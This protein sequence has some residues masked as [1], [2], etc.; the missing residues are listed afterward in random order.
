MRERNYYE[1]CFK[2]FGLSFFLMFFVLFCSNNSIVLAQKSEMY[3]HKVGM[4]GHFGTILPHYEII[5]QNVNEPIRSLD[6]SYSYKRT[7]DSIWDNIYKY[8]ELE[9]VFLWTSL[10]NKE[11]FGNEFSIVPHLRISLYQKNKFELFSKIGMGLS[12]VTKK[13]DPY[14]NV[15][16]LAIGSRVNAHF[17]F[18]LGLG[19]SLTDKILLNCGLQFG[20]FSNGNTFNP[21]FGINYLT[22]N[23]GLAYSF[24]TMQSIG[25]KT[26]RIKI[27][28]NSSIAAYFNIGLRNKPK[29]QRDVFPTNLSFQFT[30]VVSNKYQLGAGIDVFYDKSI[31]YDLQ[32]NQESFKPSY[33]FYSGVF[34][35][36]SMRY[37]NLHWGLQEGINII[38]NRSK[39]FVYWKVFVNYTF[40]ENY[41]IRLSLKTHFLTA[42]YPEIG[43][44]YKF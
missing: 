12:Y 35:S 6:F 39:E 42:D 7:K 8:P 22:T 33:N 19:Y 38:K 17:S 28:H 16:N 41:N 10:G 2:R 5:Y 30:K 1:I 24:G 15:K 18:L 36:Q 25:P 43:F 14:N 11:V 29:G 21:N 44:G 26:E 9:C 4:R 3:R 13:F 23:L 31:E 34:I 27:P 32:K 37:R 40:C 20:H